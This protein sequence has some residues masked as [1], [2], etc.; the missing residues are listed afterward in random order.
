M[1]SMVERTKTLSKE[2]VLHQLVLIRN[3]RAMLRNRVLMCLSFKDIAIKIGVDRRSLLKM[4]ESHC[5]D[6][7]RRTP[8]SWLYLKRR[9]T[10]KYG[11]WVSREDIRDALFPNKSLDHVSADLWKWGIKREYNPWLNPP[12]SI[13]F[14]D[15]VEVA[16]L[17]ETH[18]SMLIV[19]DKSGYSLLSLLYVFHITKNPRTY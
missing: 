9:I 15:I 19:R 12:P 16:R 6:P 17:V 4:C 5:I 11:P 1:V 3:T 13:P 8:R 18:E 2:E 10:K 14:R 7:T